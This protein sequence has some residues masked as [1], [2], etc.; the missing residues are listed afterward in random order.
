MKS[1][2]DLEATIKDKVSPLIEETMEKSLGISIPKIESDI[3]DQLTK[4]QLNIY[5]PMMATFEE[6]KKSFKREFLRRELQLHVGNVSELAKILGLDRRSIHRVIADLDIDLEKIREHKIPVEEVRGMQVDSVI[7]STLD[8]YKEILQ[9]AKL[10]QMY[11]EVPALSRNIARILPEEEFTWKEAEREFER[12]FLERVLREHEGSVAA[13]A[14]AIQ[15]RAET[16]H[17]KIKKL[18]LK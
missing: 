13:T 12:E 14:R 10:E 8:Q 4:P 5:V 1:K 9:P 2:R 6:A 3:S 18:G 16:L 17:R 7:R 11:Q 15:I